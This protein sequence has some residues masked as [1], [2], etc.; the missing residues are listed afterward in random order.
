MFVISGEKM[1]ESTNG[2]G[3]H[4]YTKNKFTMEQILKNKTDSPTHP[5]ED[6]HI[7][8]YIFFKRNVCQNASI[9]STS[10]GSNKK[11][12]QKSQD[13]FQ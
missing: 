7:P 5:E 6:T 4:H 12:K 1:N 2:V 11:I 3:T 13:V 8:N 9:R 10:S